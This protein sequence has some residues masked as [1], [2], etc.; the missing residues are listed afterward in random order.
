[1][2]IRNPTAVEPPATDHPNA[3]PI[4]IDLGK[5]RRAKIKKLKR[6][7]GPLLDEVNEALE[8]VRQQL[9]GD[10]QLVPVV[11]VYAKKSRKRRSLFPMGF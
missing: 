3:A 9:G 4:V 6:G 11:L 5:V 1:M 10:K 7:E 2:P 8:Q